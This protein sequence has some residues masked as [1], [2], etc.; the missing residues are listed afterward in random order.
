[1]QRLFHATPLLG[2]EAKKQVVMQLLGQAIV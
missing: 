2:H 1:M